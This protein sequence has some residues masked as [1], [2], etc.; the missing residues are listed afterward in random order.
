MLPPLPLYRPFFSLDTTAV[1]VRALV[2]WMFVGAFGDKTWFCRTQ[3]RPFLGLGWAA[4]T[5]FSFL[6][7]AF[8][9]TFQPY[10]LFGRGSFIKGFL[11]LLALYSRSKL[12]QLLLLLGHFPSCTGLL[13]ANTRLFSSPSSHPLRSMR[14]PC[15]SR[16]FDVPLCIMF[17]A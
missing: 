14:R 9:D 12:V 10:L 8:A 15:Y 2:G 16:I 6:F 1:L 5:F 7:L 4:F 3:Q 11:L 13:F 17:L